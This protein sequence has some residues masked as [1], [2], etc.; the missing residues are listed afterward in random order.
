MAK[1]IKKS[2]FVRIMQ[3]LLNTLGVS[4]KND[5][6]KTKL[7]SSD[8]GQDS[9][10]KSSVTTEETP[11]PRLSNVEQTTSEI[12]ERVRTIE[13]YLAL[14]SEISKKVKLI[15]YSFVKNKEVRSVL[16]SDLIEM[17]R[18][19]LGVRGHKK[20]FNQFCLY[21]QMQI[22]KLL[23]YYYDQRFG[24]DESLIIDHLNKINKPTY[25]YSSINYQWVLYAFGNE[26]SKT[27]GISTDI[28]DAVRML[29][30]SVIHNSGMIELSRD[31]VTAV[32]DK[33]KLSSVALH[34]FLGHNV[35][36][37]PKAKFNISSVIDGNSKFSG[38]KSVDISKF[39]RCVK[40]K[41]LKE[42]RPFDK[43]IDE[44][45]KWCNAI[46]SELKNVY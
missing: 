45:I 30:N 15:D 19:Q 17:W 3:K 18:C 1:E 7:A 23:R 13:E 37:N 34:E 12:L 41:I 43:I 32:L 27:Y 24:G 39:N 21:I 40:L 2:I 29:R 6:S 26:F 16:E 4:K 36:I 25:H 42:D 31:F 8:G 28:L 11:T 9:V 38:Y 14:G 46:Q 22:E 10:D 5:S 20:E 35:S 33:A 44:L